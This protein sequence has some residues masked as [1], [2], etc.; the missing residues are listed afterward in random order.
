MLFIPPSRDVLP[1]TPRDEH[2]FFI[3]VFNPLFLL[4]PLRVLA[5]L[6]MQIKFNIYIK[7]LLSKVD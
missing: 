5:Y 1:N 4:E 2:D 6:C 3:K 7:I